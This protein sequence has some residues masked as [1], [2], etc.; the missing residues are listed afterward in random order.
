M[1][2]PDRGLPRGRRNCD[3]QA[4]IVDPAG[5]LELIDIDRKGCDIICAEPRPTE[6]SAPLAAKEATLV[7]KLQARAE[8]ETSGLHRRIQAGVVVEVSHAQPGMVRVSSQQSHAG[9]AS[10]TSRA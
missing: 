1:P 4:L 6:S 9:S 7:P 5:F 8:R 2:A 3:R 10:A